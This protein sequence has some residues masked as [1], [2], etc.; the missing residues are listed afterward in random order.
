[1]SRGD[2]IH[3]SRWGK[4]KQLPRCKNVKPH[5]YFSSLL[6]VQDCCSSSLAENTFFPGRFLPEEPPA[7]VP[8]RTRDRRA[9]E[10]E[11][12]RPIGQSLLITPRRLP[13]PRPTSHH[14]T[15]KLLI[16]VVISLLLIHEAIQL[17]GCPFLSTDPVCPLLPTLVRPSSRMPHASTLP[18]FWALRRIDFSIKQ[19]SEATASPH[20]F[21]PLLLFDSPSVGLQGPTERQNCC[22]HSDSR[23]ISKY[24]RTDLR[25]AEHYRGQV[26]Q[27]AS[28][29]MGGNGGVV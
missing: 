8:Q 3:S 10:C 19:H 27:S 25:C 28:Y 21:W 1:M 18:H 29:W 17:Y 14:I 2:G 13:S 16:L 11:N 15:G 24:S 26:M 23:H 22:Q 6:V 20:G 9:V 7:P 5:Q 12:G 4:K